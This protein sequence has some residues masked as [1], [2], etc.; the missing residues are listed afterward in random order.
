MLLLCATLT[1]HEE[2]RYM[3]QN[4]LRKT[5]SALRKK[6]RRPRCRYY[7]VFINIEQPCV[8]SV[9]ISKILNHYA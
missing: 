3:L 6:G 5:V 4:T 1:S 7:T 8:T 9:G 2:K